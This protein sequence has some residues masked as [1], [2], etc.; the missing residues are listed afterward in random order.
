MRRAFEPFVIGESGMENGALYDTGSELEI[1]SGVWE[2]MM[3][4]KGITLE[5]G[6]G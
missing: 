6:F 4:S 2:N 3:E 5:R 1:I